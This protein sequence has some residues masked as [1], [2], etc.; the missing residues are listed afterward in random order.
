VTVG[1]ATFLQPGV[2]TLATHAELLSHF[3]NRKAISND[4][5]DGVVTLFHFAGLPQHGHPPRL[6]A[7]VSGGQTLRRS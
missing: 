6:S 1:E 4:A 7:K 2:H 5:E 3:R